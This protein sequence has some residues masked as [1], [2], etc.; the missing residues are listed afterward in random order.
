MEDSYCEMCAKYDFD[1]DKATSVYEYSGAV[2]DLIHK[3]KYDNEAWI[4]DCASKELAKLYEETGWQ[5]DIVTFVPM[6]EAKK[7]KR[8]YNQA[9]ELAKRFCKITGTE[10]ASILKRTQNTIPQSYL[11]EEERMTNLKK[12]IVVHPACERFIKDKRVLV[13]DDIMTTGSSLNECAKALKNAGCSEV[14]GLSLCSVKG[15]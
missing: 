4:A 13:I 6:Y 10:C 2:R 3:F 15:E 14:Y 7:R 5:C 1:F 12:M 9:E 11:D 8:G